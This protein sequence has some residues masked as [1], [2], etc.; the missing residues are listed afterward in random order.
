MT[1]LKNRTATNGTWHSLSF[2]ERQEAVAL[3]I[4]WVKTITNDCWVN[5]EHR[6]NNRKSPFDIAIEND[7]KPWHL[8]DRAAFADVLPRLV[9]NP[10]KLRISLLDLAGMPVLKL[11]SEEDPFLQ[12][13]GSNWADVLCH[14]AYRMLPQSEVILRK[15]D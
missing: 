14:A 8:D 11:G 15:E 4:G 12:I 13:T 3:R 5:W 10:Q 9:E 7:F 2:S 6:G 1:R